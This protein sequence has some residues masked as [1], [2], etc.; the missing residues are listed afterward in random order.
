MKK[1]E[2]FPVGNLNHTQDILRANH[3]PTRESLVLMSGAS[4]PCPE[5]MPSLHQRQA[6]MNDRYM[7]NRTAL[8]SMTARLVLK[9][10]VE[11]GRSNHERT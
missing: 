11:A 9:S 2:H 8:P 5:M 3:I 10:G 1:V 7:V 4:P 6:V